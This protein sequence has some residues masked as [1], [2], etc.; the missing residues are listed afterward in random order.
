MIKTERSIGEQNREM[1]RGR[2]RYDSGRGRNGSKKETER[3][4]VGG[5]EQER[6]LGRETRIRG[7]E[8]IRKMKRQRFRDTNRKK[9]KR[10][11]T[12]RPGDT[13]Y[14]ETKTVIEI[15]GSMVVKDKNKE[16]KKG[17]FRRSQHTEISLQRQSSRQSPAMGPL[18]GLS[19]SCSVPKDEG[20]RKRN[21][22][23]IH[24]PPT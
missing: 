23:N 19:C 12:Q 1:K 7:R 6:R 14:R 20:S 10:K 8:E 15:C 22:V 11:D 17:Q 13:K 4:E 18:P 21:K 24:G 9:G 2:E 5:R 16:R 3:R